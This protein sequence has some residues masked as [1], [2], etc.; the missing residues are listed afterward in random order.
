MRHSQTCTP[1]HRTH[2]PSLGND[3]LYFFGTTLSRQKRELLPC[4]TQNSSWTQTPSH[5][6]PSTSCFLWVGWMGNTAFRG[7][8]CLGRGWWHGESHCWEVC[9]MGGGGETGTPKVFFTWERWH[10]NTLRVGTNEDWW[11][12]AMNASRSY[13]V[14]RIPWCT[15][16]WWGDHRHRI[17]CWSA[18]DGDMIADEVALK[19]RRL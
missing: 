3:K 19:H 15:V 6:L 8:T 7:E 9:K 4:I 5:S 10:A 12:D 16:L 13:L 1:L 14:G 11:A 17:S 18:D 2:I